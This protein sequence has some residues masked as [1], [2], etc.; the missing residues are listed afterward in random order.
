M[1]TQLCRQFPD[2]GMLECMSPENWIE[3]GEGVTDLVD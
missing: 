1:F 3:D 2:F